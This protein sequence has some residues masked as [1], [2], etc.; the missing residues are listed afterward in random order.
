M[1][2]NS[3][4]NGTE[5]PPERDLIA[6]IQLYAV[7]LLVLLGTVGNL[8]S[9]AVFRCTKLRRLSTSYYL[10][11]LALSDTTFLIC[12]FVV[13]LENVKV[14]IYTQPYLCQFVTYTIHVCCFLSPWLVVTF[15]VERYVATCYPLR[16]ASVC[17]VSRAKIVVAVLT[18]IGSAFYSYTIVMAGI[19]PDMSFCGLLP[20]YE[21]PLNVLNSLDTF[22]TLVIPV[23][24]II[25]LNFQIG[26]AVWHFEKVRRRMTISL[27]HYRN[28]NGNCSIDSLNSHNSMQNNGSR[29]TATVS[30]CVGHGGQF[31]LKITK[32]LLIISSIF[33]LL[34]A[35][36]YVHR[37]WMFYLFRIAKGSSQTNTY[38]SINVT[39]ISFNATDFGTNNIDTNETSCS[40]STEQSPADNIQYI[41]TH[42]FQLIYYLNFAIN[43]LLYCMCGENFRKS[44][45][46]LLWKLVMSH[47]SAGVNVA[48][49]MMGAN[50]SRRQWS[51]RNTGTVMSTQLL[52]TEAHSSPTAISKSTQ[53]VTSIL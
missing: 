2:C 40:D 23:A 6:E 30:T 35:P 33:V 37:L 49:G 26:Y 17:T 1:E 14:H 12:I 51:R 18:F 31:Q 29:C 28:T 53:T 42:S 11:A 16:R 20:G 44:L 9:L 5:S 19:Y 13:W 15:T 41:L 38:S 36:S 32:M 21:E 50:S 27:H 34:N 47:R 8:L 25:G 43:F 46:Y 7:P 3:S 24:L 45:R 48:G 10:T 52:M 22:F 39:D 4:T